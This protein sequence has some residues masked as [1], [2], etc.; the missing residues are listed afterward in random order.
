MYFETHAHYDDKRYNK[1]R[2]EVLTSLAEN[3]VTRVVNVGADM[4]SSAASVAL[5]GKHDFIYAAVGIHPHEVKAMNENDLVNLE[6]YCANPRVVAVGEIGLDFH[7]DYSPRDVQ[8]YWFKKQLELV[9]KVALPVI[10]HSRE[11][12]QRTFDIIAKSGIRDGVIHCYSGSAEMALEYARMGFYIGIGGVITFDKTRRLANVA[13]V[14]SM[15]S[16]V[17]ETDCPYMSPEPKRGERNDSCNLK[18]IVEKLAEIRN[19]TH[20]EVAEKTFGNAE[21]LYRMD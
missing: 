4:K 9:K 17:I 5:A 16:I 6:K 3:G 18:Y 19:M 20:E 21:R 8:E 2:G 14:L 15:N 12:D 11:A 10:I 1:D 7:Y 13:N